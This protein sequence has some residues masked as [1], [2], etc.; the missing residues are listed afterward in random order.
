[1]HSDST[2]TCS[3]QLF[4][5]TVLLF[6]QDC[7]ASSYTTPEVDEKQD[8]DLISLTE[9]GGKTTMKFKRQFD[10]CDDKDNRIEVIHSLL[11]ANLFGDTAVEVS[12]L[13]NSE[14]YQPI[15]CQLINSKKAESLYQF[16][17]TATGLPRVLC[18]AYDL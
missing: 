8:Y 18:S 16:S 13:I 10:T 4:Y 9:T 2:I 15:L 7:Y 6:T 5:L 17:D 12:S 1:M 14:V 11:F 3:H